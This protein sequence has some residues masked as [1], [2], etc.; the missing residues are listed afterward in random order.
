M[1]RKRAARKKSVAKKPTPSVNVDEQVFKYFVAQSAHGNSVADEI[2]NNNQS[3]QVNAAGKNLKFS[4]SSSSS[5]SDNDESF[6]L[7]IDSSGPDE[8]ATVAK[9]KRSVSNHG[10]QKGETSRKTTNA[11][12]GLVSNVTSSRG[13]GS[14]IMP[15]KVKGFSSLSR[16]ELP[17]PKELSQDPSYNKLELKTSLAVIKK[18]MKME[19][20]GPFNAPVDPV[21]Q[22]LPD[23]FTVI[24][25]PMDFGTI[26][27]NLQ[28][29]VKYMNSDDVYKDVNYIW[30]NC[31]NYNK[32]GDYIVYLMK[33]VKKKFM[34][35]WKSAGLRTEILREHAGHSHSMASSDHTI[36]QS[37][38]DALSVVNRMVT[39]SNRMQ[40]DKLGTGQPQP[41]QPQPSTI[42]VPPFS[43]LHAGEGSNYTDMRSRARDTG[44]GH[45]RFR[46]SAGKTNLQTRVR[47]G[48]IVGAS[49]V[50]EPGP[51]APTCLTPS[52][53]Q[54]SQGMR[55]PQPS[56]HSPQLPSIFR[57]AQQLAPREPEPE[58]EPE[59]ESESESEPE[60]EPEPALAEDEVGHSVLGGRT[61]LTLSGDVML[62]SDKCSR[63]IRKII[64]KKLDVD[65]AKWKTVSQKTKEYYFQEFKKQFFW[66]QAIDTMVKH[67]WKKKAAKRY[68]DM[69]SEIRNKGVR[70]AFLSEGVWKRWLEVWSDPEY[71]RM[72]QQ[73]KLNRRKGEDGPAAACHTG[74]SVPHL[75]HRK[76]LAE[77]LGRDPTPHELFVYTHTR[78]HDGLSFVDERAKEVNERVESIREQMT[79]NS[80][81]V[82]ETQVFYEAAG[83]KQRSRV[84]GLG[85]EGPEY[86]SKSPKVSTFP[87]KNQSTELQQQL[88][89]LQQQQHA[90]EERHEERYNVLLETIQKQTEI[91]HAMQ[92]QIETAPVCAPIDVP[93]IM[94]AKAN[95]KSKLRSR[96]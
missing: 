81:T 31:R 48:V 33:R 83:G 75:K 23:Y 43:Q 59:S 44:G 66:D 22:G 9:K 20:A 6:N 92:Q 73:K 52:S 29:G 21:S 19:E 76:R 3:D 8:P 72:S 74:G 71:V 88:Q 4:S 45:K 85:S 57:R 50:D 38:H 68:S 61:E 5:S 89:Q 17:S 1:K 27:G 87:S 95:P 35:Y 93:P 25:T 42:Q 54:T 41:H 37:R 62:P 64:E 40:R 58:P 91:I 12:R 79:Q 16:K 90:T 24:D 34:N 94:A 15:S 82:D 67:A 69:L 60:P 49:M 7:E 13:S 28:N 65:G 51:S 32:K 56:S 70:P 2:N 63:A 46:D 39:N 53:S 84:Y 86:Y 77:Q 47:A 80:S 14:K 36:W 55:T 18:V 78:K 30:E 10:W 96:K 11:P 26:C